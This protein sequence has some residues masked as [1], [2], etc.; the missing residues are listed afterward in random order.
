[1]GNDF[2]A[3]KRSKKRK[4]SDIDQELASEGGRKHKKKRAAIR[5]ICKGM[6]YNEPQRERLSLSAF[7]TNEWNVPA[8]RF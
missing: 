6:C 2:E 1:M 7:N 4:G 8:K 3:R 5:R